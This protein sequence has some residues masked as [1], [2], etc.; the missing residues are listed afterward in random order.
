MYIPVVIFCL[1][2]SIIGFSLQFLS[3]KDLF[4]RYRSSI[5]RVYDGRPFTTRAEER[6]FCFIDF[7]ADRHGSAGNRHVFA[8]IRRKANRVSFSTADKNIFITD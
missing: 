6:D 2:A 4:R 5:P 8:I 1:V 7:F 3:G